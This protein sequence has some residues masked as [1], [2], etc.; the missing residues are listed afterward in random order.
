MQKSNEDKFI[1]WIVPRKIEQ[2][3]TGLVMS[4][5]NGENVTT[6]LT[7]D[8][9]DEQ[10]ISFV[11]IVGRSGIYEGIYKC[12]KAGLFDLYIRLLPKSG[13][14]QKAVCTIVIVI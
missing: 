11:N 6:S 8:E 2:Q 13:D 10:A 14:R 7:T 3:I 5:T 1:S 9:I 4:T 12:D